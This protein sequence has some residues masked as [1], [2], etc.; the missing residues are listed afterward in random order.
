MSYRFYNISK[1][2]NL[3][4]H[5]LWDG[6]YFYSNLDKLPDE[7]IKNIFKQ[8]IKANK[9]WRITDIIR[10]VPDSSSSSIIE[11]QNDNLYF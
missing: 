6:S 10:A 4:T 1:K 11:Y 9:F 3:N 7:D 5:P 8:V 2:N